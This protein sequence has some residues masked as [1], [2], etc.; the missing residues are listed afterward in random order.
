MAT[1]TEF[2]RALLG[3]I[4]FKLYHDINLHYPPQVSVL[5]QVSEAKAESKD[6]DEY[7]Y[8]TDA[9]YSMEV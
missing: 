3:F 6:E 1:F 5:N 7:K 2:Y 4:L 8:C 9:E